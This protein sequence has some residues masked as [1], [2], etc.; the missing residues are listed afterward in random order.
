MRNKPS[1]HHRQLTSLTNN[2]NNRSRTNSLSPPSVDSNNN[3]N[4]SSGH[5]HGN[6][7]KCRSLVCDS[8]GIIIAEM[9]YRCMICYYVT[10]SI[11]EAKDHYSMAHMQE[12]EE[13]DE[14]SDNNRSNNINNNHLI[15]HHKSPAAAA[16]EAMM[17]F[18]SGALG[19]RN[20][21]S[22]NPLVSESLSLLEENASLPLKFGN[23]SHHLNNTLRQLTQQNNLLKRNSEFSLEIKCCSSFYVFH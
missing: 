21:T 19:G 20:M 8:S 6:N 22:S 3:N 11:T 7:N 13:D 14:E 15:N 12:E 10:D 23:T 9:V 1:D 16:A 18:A 2:N 17:R 5:S 4:P